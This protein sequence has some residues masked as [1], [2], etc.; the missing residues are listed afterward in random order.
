MDLKAFYDQHGAEVDAAVAR[1]L[2]SG[3]YILGKEVE[4]FEAAFASELD[5]GTAAGVGNGTDALMLALRG[6]GVGPGDRVATVSHTAVATVAAVELIGAVPIFVDIDPIF[7]T[8]SPQSLARC[9]ES[10]D[11]IKAVV[12]VHLYGQPAD[13]AGILDVCRPRGIWVV[14]DCAQAHGARIG[15]TTVGGI[16]DS[17]SFSFY[18][19]KNL[20]AFGDGGAVSARNPSV[21]ETVRCLRQYGWRERYISDVPGYNSRLDEL[22]A[23][24]LNVKLGYL[25]EGNKR[26]RAIAA[27]YQT[28]LSGLNLV[29]PQ[30]APGTTHVYHQYVVRHPERDRIAAELRS[31]GIGTNIHYPVPVHLQPAYRGRLA[32]DPDGLLA[33]EAAAREVLSLPM[34]PELEDK[35]VDRVI[36]AVRS[37]V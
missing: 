31:V 30:E 18:P 27:R 36:E 2:S 5:L 8:L 1:V 22:Q 11:G 17:A 26:R 13:M 7:F 28:G 20:G 29:L 19:T 9:V 24:I 23:S 35:A 12:A 3:W 10:V 4:A 32:A 37:V 16:G 21:I 15:A 33:T 14:E 34:Y 25:A 6:L